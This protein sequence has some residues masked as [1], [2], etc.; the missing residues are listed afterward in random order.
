MLVVV[1]DL[2]VGERVAAL[3]LD[4]RV[5]HQRRQAAHHDTAEINMKF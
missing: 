4:D 1:D 2:G 3:F 5:V